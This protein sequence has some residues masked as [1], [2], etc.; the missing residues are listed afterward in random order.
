MVDKTIFLKDVENIQRLMQDKYGDVFRCNKKGYDQ[1]F[2]LAHAQKSLSMFLKHLWCMGKVQMPPLCPIDGVI[3]ND[4]LKKGESWTKLND[5]NKYNDYIKIIEDAAQKEK[6]FVAEWEYDHW[7][8][9][10][11]KRNRKNG[12]PLDEPKKQR[13]QTTPN[14]IHKKNG[15]DNILEEELIMLNGIEFTLFVG[16]RSGN[17]D[18][19]YCQIRHWDKDEVNI[20]TLPDAQSIFTAFAIPQHPWISHTKKHLYK[21][22]EFKDNE[23]SE[24]LKNAKK[25]KD[26]IFNFIQ[27]GFRN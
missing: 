22:V 21:Y 2:R 27:N 8:R 9:V 24:N 15:S 19:Y 4:V 6:K 20:N 26:M 10:I 3:L 11:E 13:K 17:T 23:E 18:H 14:L 7:N 16:Q 1:V 5:W 12:E 25:L